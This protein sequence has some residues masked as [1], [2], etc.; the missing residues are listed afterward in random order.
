MRLNG[1]IVPVGT[2][3]SDKTKWPANMY[4]EIRAISREIHPGTYRVR[5]AATS[6]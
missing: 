4:I 1:H 5:T 2:V 3:W 6:A